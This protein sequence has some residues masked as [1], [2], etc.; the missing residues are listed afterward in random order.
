MS[1]ILAVHALAFP[2][3][4]ICYLQRSDVYYLQWSDVPFA[5]LGG[6]LLLAL[7]ERFVVRREVRVFSLTLPVFMASLLLLNR[8]PSEGFNGYLPAALLVLSG[9]YG[10]W[11]YIYW[12]RVRLWFLNFIL[13][14][15]LGIP[16]LSIQVISLSAELVFYL[17][18]LSVFWAVISTLLRDVFA[19]PHRTSLLWGLC[20]TSVAIY[21]IH[22]VKLGGVIQLDFEPNV[23][24]TC[25]ALA[26]LIGAKRAQSS[27]PIYVLF[28]FSGLI[29]LPPLIETGWD[30]HSG[31]NAAIAV[32]VVLA[33]RY[34][35][36]EAPPPLAEPGIS[37]P[38]SGT[39]LYSQDEGLYRH[40]LAAC[41]V[42]F[43]SLQPE[44]GLF[45]L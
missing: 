9:A 14:C 28:I 39:R 35:L 21:I 6:L 15:L 11:R 8:G 40:S 10:Y 5:L 18:A 33:L 13:V 37:G 27:L 29:I 7:L 34:L 26:L 20:G 1:E 41:I 43:A 44:R 32:C 36:P 30:R 16:L 45:P 23:Y 42:G 2:F 12:Y 3:S 24:L 22:I 4:I 17:G 25:M 38:L 19:K 31:L